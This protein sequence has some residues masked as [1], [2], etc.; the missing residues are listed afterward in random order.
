MEY[1]YFELACREKIN[2]RLDSSDQA[3]AREELERGRFLLQRGFS[4]SGMAERYMGRIHQM[5]GENLE[6][7]PYLQA[8]RPRMQS[9][10]L[11][12]TDQA[13]VSAYLKTNQPDKAR[14]IITEGLEK[15][16]EFRSFYQQLLRLL[17]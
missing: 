4:E 12:A 5:L 10:D 6:A 15:S 16:G 11:V 8:A 2:G 17:P 9:M 7:I 14:A 3:K 13:L 1:L